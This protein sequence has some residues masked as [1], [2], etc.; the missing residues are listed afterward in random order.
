MQTWLLELHV[1]SSQNACPD[2]TFIRLSSN[3]K[4]DG[5]KQSVRVEQDHMVQLKTQVPKQTALYPLTY[6]CTCGTP[7]SQSWRK[8]DYLIRNH[9]KWKEFQS[10]PELSYSI[11]P[12]LQA[13]ETLK[14]SWDEVSQHLHCCILFKKWNSKWGKRRQGHLLFLLVQRHKRNVRNWGRMTPGWTWDAQIR[15]NTSPNS[16]SVTDRGARK[17]LD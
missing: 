10:F 12:D 17:L 16:S 7:T 9:N 6:R 2:I 11:S 3:V 4:R 13:E 1:L 14:G 15:S 5:I 8:W